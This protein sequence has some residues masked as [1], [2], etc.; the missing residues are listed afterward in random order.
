MGGP[1]RVCGDA[2]GESRVAC[3]RPGKR[4]LLTRGVDRDHA[5]RYV[6][7]A[8]TPQV[9]AIFTAAE[10]STLEGAVHAGKSLLTSGEAGIAP[11]SRRRALLSPA[12]VACVGGVPVAIY[13]LRSA[14]SGRPALG[15][16]AGLVSSRSTLD[17][18]SHARRFLLPRI[19]G[20]PRYF[21]EPGCRPG[22]PPSRATDCVYLR[23]WGR[24]W[25]WQ[26]VEPG[27]G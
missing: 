12:I 1:L 24:W 10:Q 11:P 6:Q 2:R 13:E 22:F 18:I 23:F 25:P 19:P 26:C 9:H 14:F 3:E 17:E 8:H 7:M 20:M 5:D 15:P 21:E 16:S 27:G 4:R